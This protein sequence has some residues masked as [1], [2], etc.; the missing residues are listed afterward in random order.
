M[1][2]VVYVDGFNLFYG[3]LR[4]T[5]AGSGHLRVRSAPPEGVAPG[6]YPLCRPVLNRKQVSVSSLVYDGPAGVGI[7]QEEESR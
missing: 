5:P 1:R 3:A 7:A 4:G 6:R 2:T